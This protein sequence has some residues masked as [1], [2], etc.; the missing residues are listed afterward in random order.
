[1]HALIVDGQV[2]QV[3]L[4]KVGT[5]PDGSTVSGFELLDDATLATA[6]WFPVLETAPPA[7]NEATHQLD[8]S[9]EAVDGQPVTVHTITPLPPDPDKAL[10]DNIRAAGTLAQLKAA[11]LGE[12]PA[13]VATVAARPR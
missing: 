13:A 1:M 8:T 12:D 10:K 9:I 5:L 7:Y 11:L 2:V 3:G 6:G 4:P